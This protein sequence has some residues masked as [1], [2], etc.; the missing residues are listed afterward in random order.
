MDFRFG[1]PFA[2]EYADG[3][4]IQGRFGMAYERTNMRS[5][6]SYFA[7]WAQKARGL[8]VKAVERIYVRFETRYTSKRSQNTP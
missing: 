7:F 5:T 1:M 8:L 4:E 6:V 2:E 3:K